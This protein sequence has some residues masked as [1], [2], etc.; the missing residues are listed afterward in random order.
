[1][2]FTVRDEV[3][4]VMVLHQSVCPRGGGGLPQCLLVYL[5]PLPQELTPPGA[6]TPGSRPPWSRHPQG[7]D[8]P[9][10]KQTLPGADTPWRR[11]PGADTLPPQQT[12]TIAEGTH[13]IGMYSRLK[14]KYP[15]PL[16]ALKT[17]W[18]QFSFTILPIF[19]N[20]Y[21]AV[22]LPKTHVH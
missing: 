6:G 10:G 9:P 2:I 4:K 19:Q 7:A 17:V 1:M 16:P 18:W 13:P 15:R 12:A 14:I 11:R 22:I 3:A 8:T 20:K 5:Y 21:S